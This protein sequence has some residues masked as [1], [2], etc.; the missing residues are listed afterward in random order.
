[1]TADELFFSENPTIEACVR[2]SSDE[3]I[4]DGWAWR[5]LRLIVSF[6]G[7]LWDVPLPMPCT[8]Q[9]VLFD[10]VRWPLDRDGL[11]EILDWSNG[12]WEGLLA[13]LEMPSPSRAIH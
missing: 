1:M 12:T 10:Q 2:A 11:L 7:R 6:E 9:A 5:P 3:E 13:L 4:A 8:G